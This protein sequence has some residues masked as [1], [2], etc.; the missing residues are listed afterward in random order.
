[1]IKRIIATLTICLIITGLIC[2][3]FSDASA[4]PQPNWS[5]P[6]ISEVINISDLTN[7]MLNGGTYDVS[8]YTDSES[9]MNDYF[10]ARTKTRLI[11]PGEDAED[12]YEVLPGFGINNQLVPGD[13]FARPLDTNRIIASSFRDHTGYGRRF[14]VQVNEALLDSG[15]LYDMKIPL[16][17]EI[18]FANFVSYNHD[19]LKLYSEFFNNDDSGQTPNPDPNYSTYINRINSHNPYSFYWDNT[20]TSQFYGGRITGIDRYCTPIKPYNLESW[21]SF[22][23]NGYIGEQF[24][25][26]NNGW[27]TTSYSC[28]TG[29][30]KSLIIT[31]IGNDQYSGTISDITIVPYCRDQYGESWYAGRIQYSNDNYSSQSIYWSTNGGLTNKSLSFT[32][33]LS[34]VFNYF[35]DRC[36]NVNIYVDNELWALVGDPIETPTITPEFPDAVGGEELPNTTWPI[37]RPRAPYYTSVPG[38]LQAIEDAI[39]GDG[40]LDIDDLKPYL[41]D[42]NGD[43]V[44]DPIF[45]PEPVP[46]PVPDP[47]NPDVIPGLPELPAMPLDMPG[48]NGV[49]VLAEIINFTN[50]SLPTS[51]IVTFWGIV[52]GIVILGLIKILHK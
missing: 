15:S 43:P 38:M 39:Q 24:N 10:N 42:E 36:K 21:F 16:L 41:T 6:G 22:N 47:V 18:E 1:M 44:P 51:L 26:S 34:Q 5:D 48:F 52:F 19:A 4:L 20:P 13:S 17:N 37:S 2:P 11:S 12:Y 29:D 40:K 46:I 30:I 9:F 25:Y 35:Q 8:R 50:Q 7:W 45:D 23:T 32:G 27:S 3:V 28:T 33:T 31:S 49:S 14:S